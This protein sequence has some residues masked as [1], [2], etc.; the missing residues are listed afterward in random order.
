MVCFLLS[1]SLFFLQNVVLCKRGRSDSH[2]KLNSSPKTGID[3]TA[4]QA[5]PD[6]GSLCNGYL[7]S[8]P[9]RCQVCPCSGR[10][11]TVGSNFSKYT[12]AMGRDPKD[13]RALDQFCEVLN[14]EGT[15]WFSNEPKTFQGFLLP[16]VA[17]TLVDKH[18]HL[19]CITNR[20]I[21]TSCSSYFLNSFLKTNR[22]SY[23]LRMNK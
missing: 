10:E 14:Y 4:G 1:F 21:F 19:N 13:L 5:A 15:L 22:K 8:D 17:L 18:P 7:Q 11:N 12:K 23:I 3:D 20:Y 2:K 16:T 9:T 6:K